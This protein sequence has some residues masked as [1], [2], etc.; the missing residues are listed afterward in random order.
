MHA[1]IP[2]ETGGRLI[3]WTCPRETCD[4]GCVW[5]RRVATEA[6][7]GIEAV[8][9]LHAETHG[10]GRVHVLDSGRTRTFKVWRSARGL[11]SRE[12]M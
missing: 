3:A 6:V 4:G 5:F 8:A 12:V 9:V 10:T 7:G 2:A 1:L 11:E